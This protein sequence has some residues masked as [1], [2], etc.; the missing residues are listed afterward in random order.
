[1]CPSKHYAQVQARHRSLSQI[2]P[3]PKQTMT[4]KVAE[5]GMETAH[6]AAVAA[7]KAAE[8]GAG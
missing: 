4:E 1:M 8:Q 3:V 7:K 2:P 5:A 6:S